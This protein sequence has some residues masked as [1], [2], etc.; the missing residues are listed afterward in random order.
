MKTKHLL[1][2]AVAILL[3]I[4]ITP[5]FSTVFAQGTAF[6]Y[7]GRLNGASGPVTGSYA[8]SFTLFNSSAG[9]SPFAG[10]V[11]NAPVNVTNGLFTTTV[12]FGNAFTGA[13]NWLAV[14]VSTNGANNFVTLSPRQQ[15]TPTPY[16]IYAE[17]ANAGSLI[18][19]IPAANLSVANLSG[20]ALIAGT[21]TFNGTQ[22]IT[23]GNV[24]IGTTTPQLGFEVDSQV[25]GQ[26]AAQFDVANCGVPCAQSDYQEAIR[27]WN[28]NG[29][30]Q[31][32]LGF[33]VGAGSFNSNAGPDVWLGTA[34]GAYGQANDFQIATTTNSIGTNL[35]NRFYINGNSGNV[36]IGT[37]APG[38][39]LEVNGTVTATNFSGS[40]SGLTSVALL[41]AANTFTAQQTFNVSPF[42]E[43]CVVTDGANSLGS[44]IGAGQCSFGTFTSHGLGFF[45]NNGFDSMFLAVNGNFG[46]GTSLPANK[47]DVQGSADFTGDVG[48]GTSTPTNTLQ[49]NGTVAASALRAPGAGVNTGTFAFIQTAVSTNT[50]AD[51]TFIYN[52]VCDGDPNA[53]LIVTHNYAADTNS[54]S[55]YNTT[56]VGVY[57]TTGRWAIFNEDQSGMALGRAF[58]VM[59]IKN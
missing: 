29:N 49:V 4:S 56:P 32:G 22:I 46:I 10:P 3:V 51:Q 55:R 35:V 6:T 36:G 2:F 37:T 16:A 39:A 24:G 53:I 50:F 58:N 28:Q 31:V 9:G 41:S 23:G 48:I 20:V 57:Y 26:A 40:G 42:D 44:Y 19:I 21:N 7:Q 1:K 27:L 8:L 12:D 15:L 18:G 17:S 59:V 52:P 30:G 25:Y 54:T 13:S 11:T 34:Y 45:V 43:G 47:L 5:Q 33:L 38:T 14:A